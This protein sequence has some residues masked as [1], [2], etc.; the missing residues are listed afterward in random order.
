[1]NASGGTAPYSYSWNTVPPQTTQTASGLTAGSYTV[2]ITDGSCSSQGPQL[3]SNGNFSAGNTGFSSSYTNCGTPNCLGP[4]GMYAVDTNPNTYHGLFVGADHTTG[5]GNFMIVNGASTPGVSIWCQTISVTPN[6]TYNFS[7]W[8]STLYSVSPAQLQFS[9]N[10]LPVGPIFNAPG[11]TNTWSQFAATWNSGSN[12]SATICI[13]NQNTNASGNDFGLDD[14]SFVA[15]T[16]CT[17]TAVVNIT[18]PPALGGTTS[19]TTATCGQANG[20]ATVTPA[21][22]TTPYSYSWSSGGSSDTETGL[23]PGTYT[24]TVTDF[25]G[26]TFT[27]TATVPNAGGP[28]AS[29]SAFTDVT[30]FGANDGTASVTVVGGTL[31]LTYLWTP[32]G[33][34]SANATGLGPNIYTCTVTDDNGCV[35]SVTVAITEPPA[36]QITNTAQTDVSCFGGSNGSASVTAS[37]GTG[38]LTYSWS[39]GG[40]ASTESNLIAGSYTCT[41]TDANGC[42]IQQTFAITEPPQLTLATAGFDATCFGVCDGQVIVI[43]NG[44]VQPYQFAWDNGCTSPSCTGLCAGTYNVTVTDANGCTATGS[45][46][47]NEPPQITTVMSSATAHCNQS[48]GSAFVVS[49][50]GTGSHTYSWSPLGGTND[51]ALNLLPGTYFVTVTDVNGCQVVDSIAVANAPGVAGVLNASTNVTCFGACDGTADVLA[52]SGTPPYTYAWLPTGG[53]AASATGLCAGQYTC[54]VTDDAGCSATVTVTITEPAQLTVTTSANVSI[55]N[56]QNTQITA[57]AQGGTAP[58]NYDWT[59]G[60]LNGANQT[61]SPAA[62]TTYNITVTDANGCTAAGSTTVTVNPVPVAALSSDVQSGC[63]PLDVNFTDASGVALPGAIISW[64]WDFGDGNTSTQQNPSHTYATPGVYT[65]TLT[66]TTA[67]GCTQT[68]TMANYIS[69]YAIPVAEFTAGPQPTTILNP[70][71][72]FTDQSIGAATWTWSFGDVANSSSNLANPQFAYTDTICHDVVLT[73]TSADGCQDTVVHPVC[74][75]PDFSIYVPNTFTPNDD[76]KNDIFIPVAIG[77]DLSTYEMWI[78]DRWG[79]LIYYT[80]DAS[81]GWNGHANYGE[82]VAQIDTYVWKIRCRDFLEQKHD[83]IGHVNLIK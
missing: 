64:L 21:G 62:T 57:N 43:P 53:N 10:S 22:G 69:V 65:V 20:S 47:V 39:S 14:I 40:T 80:D 51:T 4:A 81:K 45:A 16:S 54:T 68:I 78:F 63:E 32:A 72:S 55:C 71:I 7:A 36:L 52:N 19:V 58:Y 75:G 37:G 2:T 1:V 79:N 27:V 76:G 74:I 67:D 5:S 8:V 26:C 17:T 48:D 33:G 70:L 41:I 82:E 15:C 59:P 35:S 50:G 38:T 56:G 49:G 13:I 28:T 30:C 31:P 66:V 25:N 61:V 24:V 44:G 77:L 11:S 29:L 6:T 46:T 12:T 9:I 34:N 3:V 83:Y 73:V 42:S 60:P 18:E 23:T